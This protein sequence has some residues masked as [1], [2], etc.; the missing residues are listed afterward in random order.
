M[1]FPDF[2]M[3]A[4]AY[5]SNTPHLAFSALIEQGARD[6][7]YITSN[8]DKLFG[9]LSPLREETA[10]TEQFKQNKHNFDTIFEQIDVENMKWFSFF[11][12]FGFCRDL[13]DVQSALTCCYKQKVSK[14][15]FEKA[16]LQ[17]ALSFYNTKGLN[18]NADT[19]TITSYIGVKAAAQEDKNLQEP[20]RLKKEEPE[21]T[22]KVNS[23]PLS[24]EELEDAFAH[25]E[26]SSRD[27]FATEDSSSST[28]QLSDN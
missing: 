4:A 5:I 17:S 25:K 9:Q 15:V 23:L 24:S 12:A 11:G 27:A 6:N 21:Q 16:A 2:T 14:C 18:S 8:N 10:I 28:E 20:V 3:F 1:I 13:A 7:V 22:T 26:S 19:Q